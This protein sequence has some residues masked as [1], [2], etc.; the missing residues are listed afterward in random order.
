MLT[1]TDLKEI[2]KVVREEVEAEGK[3]IRDEVGD[4]VRESRIRVQQDIRELSD[5]IKNLEIRVNSMEQG[6]KK[7]FEKVRK[8]VKNSVNFLDKDY[9]KLRKRVETIE[10][11]L[12]LEPTTP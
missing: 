7:E 3:N 8:E 2:K 11:H 1:K 5:R 10:K 6:M 9:V 12:N 4:S